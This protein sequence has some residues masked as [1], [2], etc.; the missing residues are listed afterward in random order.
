MEQPPVILFDGV[1]N[2]CNGAINFV[3]RQDR[4]KRLRFA[5]LQSPAGQALLKQ[6]GLDKNTFD[7]FVLIREGKVYRKSTAALAVLNELPW[8]WK[9]AQVLRIVP[10]FL[11]DTIYDFIARNRYRWF[12]RRDACMVPTADMRARFI[13]SGI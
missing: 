8:Y 5:P 1:C 3:L 12:G 10:R 13:E 6:Y 2:F 7:S 11:R 9:E 4:R